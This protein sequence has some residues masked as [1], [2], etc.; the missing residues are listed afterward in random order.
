MTPTLCIVVKG[1]PRVSETFIT[2]EL[3]ALQDASLNFTISSLRQK[4]KDAQKVSHRVTATPNYL[5]E[6]LH[7]E[8]VRVTRSI[9]MARRYEGFGR[10][11]RSFQADLARDLTRNRVRRFG[12]ACVLAAEL[13]DSVR[14]LH[15]HFIHTPASVARYAAE[16]RGLTFSVSA[17]AKDIWTTPD[18]DLCEKLEAAQFVCTCNHAGAQ[19][20]MNLAPEGK[21]RTWPH[22]VGKNT[23][24]AAKQARLEGPVRLLTVARAVPKKGLMIL[25]TALAELPS[26]PSWT[27]THIG[28]GPELKR[29][30]RAVENHPYRERLQILGSQSHAQVLDALR[31]HDVFVL[32]AVEAEDGDRDGRP[33]ALIEAMSA[34]LACVASPVGGIPELLAEGIGVMPRSEPQAFASALTSLLTTQSTIAKLG[35]AAKR[36]ADDLRA[37]G[38]ASL[39]ALA[40][41]LREAAGQ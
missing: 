7:E 28:G 22:L 14:H 27:W 23:A 21:V 11:W 26:E 31:R 36:R 41:A 38:N 19:R 25:L 33:N 29:L 6:Y 17:H 39:E 35:D 3:E 10:A 8:P 5:P 15:A 2:K 16:I 24:D 12:Q 40:R 37:E 18:W 1:F 30:K 4:T 34:G 13:P 9:R 32:A 20:L